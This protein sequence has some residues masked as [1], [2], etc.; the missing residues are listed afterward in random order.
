MPHTAMILSQAPTPSPASTRGRGR[1][2]SLSRA[3]VAIRA[4]RKRAHRGRSPVLGLAHSRVDRGEV[5]KEFHGRRDR[6]ELASHLLRDVWV[7]GLIGPLPTNEPHDDHE[8]APLGPGPGRP[9]AIA[10]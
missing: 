1:E 10:A 7:A 2:L 9:P 3:K 4:G 6:A 8:A 5:R